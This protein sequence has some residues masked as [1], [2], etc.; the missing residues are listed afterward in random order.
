MNLRELDTDAIRKLLEATDEEGRPLHVDVLR[1]LLERE[2][3]F[4]RNSTCPRCR[5]ASVEAF[6]DPKRPFVSGSI[7]PN[8]HLRCVKCDTEFDPYSGLIRRTTALSE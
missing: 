5:E 8:R 1:P 3:A 7:L 6:V 4:F 2:E